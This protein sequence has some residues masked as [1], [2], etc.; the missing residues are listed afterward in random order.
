[1]DHTTLRG[2]LAQTLQVFLAALLVD[3]SATAFLNAAK[4]LALWQDAAGAAI[5]AALVG[6]MSLA[7]A[8]VRVMR[9]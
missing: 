1:M 8:Q 7:S 5:T 4:N 6:L 9:S 2:V 3:D